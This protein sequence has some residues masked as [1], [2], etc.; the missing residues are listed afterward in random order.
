MDRTPT[1][2]DAVDSDLDTLVDTLSDSFAEDP[3]FNW[4]FPQRKLYSHF[5]Q[6]LVKDVYLERGIVHIEQQGRAAALWLPPEERLK[7]A[8]RMGLL[9]FGVN[10]V[11]QGG[12]RPIWRLLQQ[13][14]VFSKHQPREPHY[15]LQFIGCR[16]D[17]QG[18]G[19]GAAL[20]KQGIMIC[21]ER[22]M[23]AYLECSNPRNVPLYER[24][25]FEVRSQQV[26]GKNGPM[27]WFMWRDSR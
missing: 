16:H 19:I 11:K 7:S 26:V 17:H 1:I 24:H 4:V 22:G 2:R 20:L 27:A 12:L 14:T 5:F 18:Q 21:D 10:L 25:G 6:M 9:G 15:Y 23:P 13:G 8:P 3:M